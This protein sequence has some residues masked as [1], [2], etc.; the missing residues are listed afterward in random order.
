MCELAAFNVFL[1][2]RFASV[3]RHRFVGIFIIENNTLEGMALVI[4][5]RLFHVNIWTKPREGHLVTLIERW[6][7]TGQDDAD[8]GGLIATLRC[9][10]TVSFAGAV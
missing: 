8:Y 6:Q 10:H 1:L 3:G 2:F 4:N 5:F 7:L 9:P